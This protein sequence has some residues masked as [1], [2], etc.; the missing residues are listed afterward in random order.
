M[1]I[2]KIISDFD[3][4]FANTLELCLGQI[5]TVSRSLGRIPPPREEMIRLWGTQFEKFLGHFLP[6]ITMEMY[7]DK[8]REFGFD[9]AIPPFFEGVKEAIGIISGECP[10]SIVS[11]RE[12]ESLGI[13]LKGNGFEPGDFFYVQSASDTQYHKPDPRAF[14]PVLRLLNGS[15]ERHEILYVGDTLIDYEAA[16]GAGLCFAGVL[17]GGITTAEEFEKSGVEPRY[18]L[19]S[20]ADLPGRLGSF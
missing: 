14:D 10:I 11:N 17:S 8:W 16:A 20:F 15:M 6:G 3:G 1:P 19:E 7:L 9:R 12:K 13:I 2:K 18:I 5:E 4:V